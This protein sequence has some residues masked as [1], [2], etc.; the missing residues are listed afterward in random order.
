MVICFKFHRFVV[1]IKGRYE[2]DFTK[3]GVDTTVSL[4]ASDVGRHL[5]SVAYT[6]GCRQQYLF[7]DRLPTEAIDW[8]SVHGDESRSVR[9]GSIQS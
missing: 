2:C 6:S 8:L 5:V 1:K 4:Q 7:A 3:H 9:T